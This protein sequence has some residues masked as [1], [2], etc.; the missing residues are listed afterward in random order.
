MSNIDVQQDLSGLQGYKAYPA[1]YKKG[2]ASD[3]LK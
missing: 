3:L 2:G 1:W